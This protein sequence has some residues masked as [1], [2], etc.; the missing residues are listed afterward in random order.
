MV[1]PLPITSGQ[2]LITPWT[3]AGLTS[4]CT[5]RAFLGPEAVSLAVD[6]LSH[7]SGSMSPCSVLGRTAF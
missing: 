7:G 1:L 2:D 4:T 6:S 3:M 5:A